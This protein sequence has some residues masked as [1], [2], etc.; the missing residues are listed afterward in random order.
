MSSDSEKAQAASFIAA[1]EKNAGVT[2]RDRIL[3]AFDP[4]RILTYDVF[5]TAMYPET[6]IL[7][8]S[9][10]LRKKYSGVVEWQN[11]ATQNDLAGIIDAKPLVV[12]TGGN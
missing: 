3:Y 8:S 6:V 5:Q 2:G 9:Y 12:K 7:D 1:M 4:D 11:K 10:R